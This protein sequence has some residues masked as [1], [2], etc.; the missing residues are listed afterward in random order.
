L[1]YLF[2]LVALAAAG[3]LKLWLY[4]RRTRT[5]LNEIAGFQA[6]LQA[7]SEQT[8]P[9]LQPSRPRAPQRDR[10][11]PTRLDPARRR[12]AKHRIEARRRAR[13]RRAG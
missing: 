11:R 12:A 6:G 8:R 2:F 1:I 9:V 5:R 3:I 13:A 7:I 4:Q 10:S